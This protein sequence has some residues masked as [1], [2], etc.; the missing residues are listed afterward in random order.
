MASNGP[1]VVVDDDLD[2]QE[3]IS[4]LIR[5]VGATNKILVFSRCPEAYEYLVTT[6]DSPFL[7]ISDIN[8]PAMNGIEFK[9]NIDTN[10]ELRQKSIPFIFFS[11]AANKQMVNEAYS[12]LILQGF[13]QKHGNVEE[14]KNTLRIMMDYW[15]VCKHP[16]M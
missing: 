7:I 1:I 12:K 6:N 16:N 9:L 2:D 5:E 14:I 8:M 11:T 4:S 3:I 13:F 10:P 15:K